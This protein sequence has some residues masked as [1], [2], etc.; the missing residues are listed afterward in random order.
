MFVYS[1]SLS[2]GGS[3]LEFGSPVYQQNDEDFGILQTYRYTCGNWILVGKEI[4]GK[5]SN[6]WLGTSFSMSYNGDKLAVGTPPN[7]LYA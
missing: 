7:Y 1:I 4:E 2:G 3:T 5:Q 6:S